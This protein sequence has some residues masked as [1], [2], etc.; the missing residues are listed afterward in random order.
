MPVLALGGEHGDKARASATASSV[1][2]TR[3]ARR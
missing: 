1:R 2:T 3:L